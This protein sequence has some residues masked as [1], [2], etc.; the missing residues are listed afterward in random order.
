MACVCSPG[1]EA[2]V[3]LGISNGVIS[4]LGAVGTDTADD[5]VDVSGLHILPGLIDS[6][7]HLRDPGYAEAETLATGT[8]ATVLGGV[9][10]VFD[11][12]NTSPAIDN[13][14]AL[15]WKRESFAEQAYCDVGLYVAGTKTNTP[16]LPA[17]ESQPGVCA[18][19]VFAGSSTGSLL[20]EDDESLELLMRSGRRRLAFHTE[21]EYRLNERRKMFTHGMPYHT[22]MEWRDVECAYLGTRRIV[23]LA[24]KTARPAHILHIS[25]AEE[26]SFLRGHRDI[27]TTEVLVNQL[28]LEQEQCEIVRGLYQPKT[29]NS[30]QK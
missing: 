5:T 17:L 25:T 1:G 6:H 14:Q 29:V 12:P 26:L 11:M 10:T 7:V 21:D 8:R 15:L 18:I 22:H 2:A 20:V 9:T 23:S 4:S 30:L 28:G 27:V 13:S 16:E 24:R 19:K 3:D